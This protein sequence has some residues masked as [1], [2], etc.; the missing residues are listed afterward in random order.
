MVPY[1]RCHGKLSTVKCN[2]GIASFNAHFESLNLIKAKIWVLEVAYF[3]F[4]KASY[5]N[6]YI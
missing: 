5:V 1:I 2:G 3:A 4:S 6:R